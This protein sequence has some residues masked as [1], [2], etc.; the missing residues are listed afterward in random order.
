MASYVIEYT[1]M[2]TL[3][4]LL[5]GAS[6][7]LGQTFTPIY[8]PPQ[9]KD[10]LTLSDDQIAKITTLNSQFSAFQ[11][12]KTAR[13]FQV[14]REIA[15]ETAKVS[16]DPMALGVRYFELEALRR[17]MDEQQKN[18]VTQIQALLTADQKTKLAALQQALSLYST[19]CSAAGQNLMRLPTQVP[20]ALIPVISRGPLLGAPVLSLACTGA[21]GVFAGNFLPQ[22]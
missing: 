2:R 8:F 12:E 11:S 1:I 14:Q 17:Q 9:L 21:T 10:Y 19:A 5:L 13:V 6:A 7:C 18:T 22:P 3:V 16:P 20:T 4:A 15:D